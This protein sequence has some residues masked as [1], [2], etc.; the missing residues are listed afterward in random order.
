MSTNGREDPDLLPESDMVRVG[1]GVAYQT[2]VEGYGHGLLVWHWC[3]KSGWRA[4]AAREGWTVDEEAARPA[5]L[6][7]AVGAHDLIS[8][9]PLHLEPSVFWPECCGRHGFIRGG[10]WTDA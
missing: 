9:H 3:T 4:R 8:L 1:P 10:V 5:W 6:P 7:T 2:G